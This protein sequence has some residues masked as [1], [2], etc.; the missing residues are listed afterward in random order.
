MK[1]IF[2]LNGILYL[3]IFLFLFLKFIKNYDKSTVKVAKSFS[4]IGLIY[5]LISLSSILWFFNVLSYSEHDF[6]FL[7]AVGLM[8]QSLILFRVIYLFSKN[9]RLFYFLGI[10]LV[11]LF[12]LFF[13]LGNF[14]YLSLVA[15]SLFT[16]L[17]F[18][19]FTFLDESYRKAGYFG[20]LYATFSIIFNLI[21]FVGKGN[22]YF[23]S[24]I[25]GIFFLIFAYLFLSDLRKFPLNTTSKIKKEKSY[26]FTLLGH[27]I[28]IIT[29]TNFVFIGTVGI[30]E[31]GHYSVSKFYDCEYQQIVYDGDFFHTDILCRSLESNVGVILG[32]VLLPLIV[33]LLLFLMG[34]KFMKE[35]ALL[36]FGFNL[37]SISRDFS[38]LGI[39]DNLIFISIFCG[40]LILIYGLFLLAKSKS[41]ETLYL[42]GFKDN[43]V[44]RSTELNNGV[45]KR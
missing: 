36:I 21:L 34:G 29:L 5:F 17:I 7:Y 23:F 19:E 26:L 12:S 22:V 4:F 20:I 14:L 33:A 6:L 18:I 40:V 1:I 42:E 2:L 38:D 28:F 9:K 16:L 41:E 25:S 43:S 27:L 13:S 3:G 8:L 24:L 35:I 32:G 37:I 31:F 11:I 44:I 30:H 45:L 10:Y 39:S 15:S